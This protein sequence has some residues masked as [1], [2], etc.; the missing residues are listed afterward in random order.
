VYQGLEGLKAS[1][2]ELGRIAA[3]MWLGGDVA[4]SALAEEEIADT[5]ETEPEA[6]GQLPHRA[7]AVLVRLHHPEA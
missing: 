7:F 6:R 3:P 5:T 2:I 1:D 4:G